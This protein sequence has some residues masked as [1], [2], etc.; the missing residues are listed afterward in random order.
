[1]PQILPFR[2]Y[3]AWNA[4]TRNSSAVI[5]MLV[6]IS[7]FWWKNKNIKQLSNRGQVTKRLKQYEQ[8]TKR[9][10]EDCFRV[11]SFSY[12]QVTIRRCPKVKLESHHQQSSLIQS[13]RR[14]HQQYQININYMYKYNP[15]RPKSSQLY[16]S[17]CFLLPS[18]YFSGSDKAHGILAWNTGQL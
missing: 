17:I 3:Q 10:K 2:K 6:E 14:V 15:S 1:M 18:L 16:F 4:T 8:K 9:L 7:Q 13:P 12:R 5:T 11:E